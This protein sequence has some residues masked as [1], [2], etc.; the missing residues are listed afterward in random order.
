[1]IVPLIAT[2]IYLVAL[3]TVL[4]CVHVLFVRDMM[5]KIAI[6]KSSTAHD[7]TS[8]IR[9]KMA[10]FHRWQLPPHFVGL[11]RQF[12]HCQDWPLCGWKRSRQPR[13]ICILQ[14]R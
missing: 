11:L 8:K 3:A 6:D 2:C 7:L 12:F 1:M 10:I 9:Y 4:V 13:Y 5:S 14:H